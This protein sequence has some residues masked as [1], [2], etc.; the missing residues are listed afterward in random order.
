[1]PTSNA[2][3]E[4][5]IEM[6]QER[7]MQTPSLFKSD[8]FYITKIIDFLYNTYNT[9]TLSQKNNLK[10]QKEEDITDFIRKNLKENDDF[11]WSGFTV[12]TEPRN[13]SST[14]GYYDLKFE[15]PAYWINRYFVFECKLMDNSK[16]KIDAYIHKKS[17]N[18]N[19]EDGGIYRFLINKYAENLPF[20]GM[21]GYVISNE[22]EEVTAN[23]KKKIQS[24]RL[25]K[26]NLSF[27]N[28]IDAELIETPVPDFE[29]SFQSNHVRIN[30]RNQ[31]IAPIHI[32]HLFLDLT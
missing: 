15:N 32:F 1:M 28:L 25:I 22:P 10:I 18:T 21:L 29:Y 13:E 8:D 12:N 9:I 6:Q 24:F 16:A 20:G 11:K 23:L 7:Y 19:S 31:V 4:T 3:S 5:F 14:I 27:G 26:E 17:T 2:D 30:S